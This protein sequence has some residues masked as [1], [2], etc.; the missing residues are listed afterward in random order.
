MDRRIRANRRAWDIKAAV[1]VGGHSGYAGGLRALLGGRKRWSPHLPDDPGPVRGKS[2][3]HLQC[4]FGLDSLHWASRGAR[5]TGVDFSPKAVREARALAARTGIPAVFHEADVCALPR[6]LAGRFDIV[7]TYYGTICWL[8][9]LRGW[10]RGI[11]RALKPGGFF[12]IADGH[13]YLQTLEFDGPKGA[14]RLAY[15][16]F[17]QGVDRYVGEGTYAAPRAKT[18]KYVAYEW[19]HSLDEIISALRGAGLAIDFLHEFPFAFYDV[20]FYTDRK[21]FRED[22]R[23]FWHLKEWGKKLPLM[24]SIRA[25]KPRR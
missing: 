16:Y 11:A 18:G 1:H 25:V 24:F 17:A 22:R 12:Y 10:A 20:G 5:V 3:L 2:L 23:G 15:P 13:P 6:S 4:H 8:G 7:L 9:N 19:R 21:L 14:A